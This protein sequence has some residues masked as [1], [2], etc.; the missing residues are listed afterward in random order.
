MKKTVMLLAFMA[1]IS[2]AA[3][4]VEPNGKCRIQCEGSS[5]SCQIIDD[6][7]HCVCK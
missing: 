1:S 3:F 6:K 5:A 7:C 2:T 4:A